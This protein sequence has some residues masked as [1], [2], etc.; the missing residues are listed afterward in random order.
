MGTSPARP[1]RP[2]LTMHSRITPTPDPPDSDRPPSSAPPPL[3]AEVGLGLLQGEEQLR[4]AL[5]SKDRM[6]LLVLAKELEAF[7]AR[8]A[9]GAV[10]PV[11][12]AASTSTLA[13][14]AALAPSAPIAAVPTSK[15]QRMLVYKAA[16]WY[17]LK[18]V[19]GP[20]ASMVVGVLGQ[21]NEK[22]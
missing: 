19:S 14:L 3:P 18:A 15:F 6:F 1:R 17:G 11:P 16:E 2:P 13:A 22:R 9:A 8:A 12:P 10:P 21:L 5:Q 20:E 7:L 4:N